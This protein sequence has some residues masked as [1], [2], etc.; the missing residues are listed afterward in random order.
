[1]PPI[2]VIGMNNGSCLGSI[3]MDGGQS[4][5]YKDCWERKFMYAWINT[6]NMNVMVKYNVCTSE[7]GNLIR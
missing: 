4:M 1:M 7:D 5:Q 2:I 3:E 6:P